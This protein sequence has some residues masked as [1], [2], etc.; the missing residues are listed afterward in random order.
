MDDESSVRQPPIAPGGAR[1]RPTRRERAPDT[2][3]IFG[4]EALRP[5]ISCA[6]YSFYHSR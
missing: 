5:P 6:S 2:P 1:P 3:L 4:R